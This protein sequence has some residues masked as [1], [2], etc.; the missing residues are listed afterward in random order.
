MKRNDYLSEY[1]VRA[2]GV[3][4]VTGSIVGGDVVGCVAGT[5]G[6]S[7]LRLA[8]VAVAVAETGRTRFAGRSRSLSGILGARNGGES[9]VLPGRGLGAL[10]VEL[11]C[12]AVA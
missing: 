10:A 11:A 6:A 8:G 2:R 7:A 3:C 1:S 4:V 12:A 9:D 5:C